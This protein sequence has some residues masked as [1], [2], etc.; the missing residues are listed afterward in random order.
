MANK[1][2]KMCS[3]TLIIRETKMK[4]TL[5][6]HLKPVGMAGVKKTRDNMLRRMWRKENLYTPGGNINW[7][8]H[9]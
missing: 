8:S 5:R 9:Y 4:A 7:Y 6:Y 2:M 3:T 1:Y